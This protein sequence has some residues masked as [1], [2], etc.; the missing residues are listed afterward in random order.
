MVR[1][2]LVALTIVS[3]AIAVAKVSFAQGNWEAW[4]SSY[5]NEFRVA[6]AQGTIE[7][8]YVDHSGGEITTVYAANLHDIDP[9][10]VRLGG[11]DGSNTYLTMGCRNEV[12]CI[13]ISEQSPYRTRAY[14]GTT[15]GIPYD[16]PDMTQAKA[17]ARVALTRLRAAMGLGPP[18]EPDAAAISADDWV[19]SRGE[20]QD[21]LL[22]NTSK[23]PITAEVRV[24]NVECGAAYTGELR[25]I[26]PG[27]IW[28]LAYVVPFGIDCAGRTPT[29]QYRYWINAVK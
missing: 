24:Y 20:I 5:G 2:R 16:M 17:A 7:F 3:S 6:I 28:Q 27:Q 8:R 26:R 14:H 10:S 25:A 9:Q 13:S 21:I 19:E 12:Q 11:S 15:I 18:K 4:R 1:K 23:I 29:F 22:R